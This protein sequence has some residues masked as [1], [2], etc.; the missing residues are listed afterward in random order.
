M[1]T[2]TCR[3]CGRVVPP[4]QWSH[5]RCQRCTM[6]WRAH[7]I[8]RPL[9]LPPRPRVAPRLCTHC[10]QP[11]WTLR[12]GRCPPCYKYWH[13]HGVERPLAPHACQTCGQPAQKLRRG[14]CLA[15]YQYWYRTGQE[16]PPR[17]W[18]RR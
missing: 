7:G 15:C 5:E 14:R 13:R 4:G 3:I 9:R 12:R 17:L 8:E 1:A 16:R 10:G 6:Y 18:A 11:T 2:R